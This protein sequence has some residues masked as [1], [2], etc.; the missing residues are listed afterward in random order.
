VRVRRLTSWE[1]ESTD[2]GFSRGR[3]CPRPLLAAGWLK[4]VEL[5]IGIVSLPVCVL[6]AGIVTFF[7]LRD[8]KIACDLPTMIAVLALGGFGCAEIGKRLPVIRNLGAA[9]IFATFVPS[10][11]VF[12]QL[13]P[14]V[15]LKRSPSSP[16]R[17]TSFI[18]S[19]P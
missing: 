5:R 11:L 8:G 19:S 7:I 2:D 9:A 18:S 12:A 15:M 10:Y 13:L 16:R 1:E 3:A 6:P 4:L 14:E 17:P